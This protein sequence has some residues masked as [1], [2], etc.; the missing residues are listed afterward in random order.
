MIRI[1]AEADVPEILDIYAPYVKNTTS[2]FEYE[3]PTMEAFTARFRKIT[4]QFPWL[5]WEEQGMILGYAYGSLPFER[6]GYAWIAEVS[7]YLR[8]EAQGRGIGRLLYTALEKLL[9]I[10]G[11]HLIYA[12]ITGENTGSIAFHKKLGYEFLAEFP[13]CGYKHGK[14][15]SVVWLEKRLKFVEIPSELPAQFPLIVKNDGNLKNILANF[16]LS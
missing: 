7:I 13:A 10:Q 11:Y 4:A 1:A 8:P 5:V 9:T 16:T 12:I 15:L 2:S 6:A 3:V 14:I